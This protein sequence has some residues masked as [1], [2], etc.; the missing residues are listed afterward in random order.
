[1]TKEKFIPK[2]FMRNALLQTV[3]GSLKV[4]NIGKNP[5]VECAEEMILDAGNSVR[6]Q[7]YYSKDAGN[8]KGTVLLIHGWEGSSGSSYILS[9]GKYLFNNN[10]DIF[11]LNLRD[12]GESHHLNK[13]LFKSTLIE[14]TFNAAK[15]AAAMNRN[16]PFFII[17]F[18][19][20]GNFALR[21]ALKNN[22][23]KIANLRHVA[24]V[25]PVLD[26]MKSTE[27]TDRIYIIKKYFMKKWKKSL[28][29]KL[30][31]F[32]DFYNFNGLNKMRSLCEMM[33]TFV[34]LY[35]EFKSTEDYYRKYTLL[36]NYFLKL[37][38]PVTIIS[39]EDDP[40]IPVEDVY[41]LKANK[42]LNLLIQPY[43]GHSGFFDFFPYKVW[44]EE[45]LCEI[46]NKCIN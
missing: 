17:G 15:K 45:K 20:G 18:S 9:T 13:E 32:P 2:F 3:L 34:P 1:M 42:Y 22:K 38:T 19:L 43:G 5:M 12:H 37:K 21:I 25:C 14:E 4:R 11:R 35:T 40:V 23:S 41:N 33:D 26:P 6:L 8:S 27:H 30:E 44:Y 28:L 24:A 46:F 29:K 10:F 7:G 36:N 31:L 16:K 39:S